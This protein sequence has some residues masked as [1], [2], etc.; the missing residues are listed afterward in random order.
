MT[1]RSNELFGYADEKDD[2]E[3][4]SLN[5]GGGI[6]AIILSCPVPS[7]IKVTHIDLL[8]YILQV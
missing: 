6:K 2:I 4:T 8:F 5:C 3:E 7:S 1:I